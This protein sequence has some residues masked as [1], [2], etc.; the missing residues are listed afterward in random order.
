MIGA[1]HLERR[2]QRWVEQGGHQPIV[3]A[4]AGQGRVRQGVLYDPHQEALTGFASLIVGR[5]QVGQIRTIGQAAHPLRLDVCGQ[6][7][8][9]LPT[10][11]AHC[12]EHLVVMEATVPNHQHFGGDR[13][14][15]AEATD[16]LTGVDR[17]KAGY[18][19]AMMQGQR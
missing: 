1:G 17:P 13:A 7:S 2:R 12:D 14:Q 16:A 15:Q 3:L 19:H 8:Q 4:V 10:S 6:A 9:D 11:L 5:C 18:R